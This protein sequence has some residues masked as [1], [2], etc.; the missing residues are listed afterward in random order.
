MVKF[1]ILA[2]VKHQF[3]RNLERKSEVRE[4]SHVLIQTAKRYGLRES[5]ADGAWLDVAMLEI[6]EET[7]LQFSDAPL[8][9]VVCLLARYFALFMMG[10]PHLLLH[11]VGE[12]LVH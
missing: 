2:K 1:V 4:V 6:S 9:P 8:K 5:F 10:L 11:C 12:L 3:A 7:S